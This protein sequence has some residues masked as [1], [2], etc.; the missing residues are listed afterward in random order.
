VLPLL[1]HGD[2]AFMGQGLVAETLNLAELAGYTTGGTVHVIIN[3]QVGFTTNPEEGRSCTYASGIAKI[4][5]APVLHVNADDPEAVIWTAQLAAEYR[6]RFQKD[7]VIDLIGY[8]RHGHNETDEPGFTQP[9]MYKLIAKHPTVLT[10]YGE[11]LV[12]EGTLSA[13]EL[14]KKQTDFRARLQEAYDLMK[15]GDTKSDKFKDKYPKVFDDIFHPVHGDEQ[16]MEKPENTSVALKVL[17]EIGKKI[18]AMPSGFNVHP[19]LQKLLEQRSKMVDKDGPGV[20]WPMA[21]LL[22]QI[23]Y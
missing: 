10:Q 15:S 9:T 23:S 1:I 2:A 7:I 6:Q 20:D 17:S 18:A 11:R 22:A 12:A 13:E 3:N 5:K 21:E 14:K 16:A 4:V 19:K 8:R